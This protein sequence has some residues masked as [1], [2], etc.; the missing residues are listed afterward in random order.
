M[1]RDPQHHPRLWSTQDL[2]DYLGVAI[3]TLHA[4]RR[5]GEGPP[6]YRVGKV[7]RFDPAEVDTWLHTEAREPSP[8]PGQP[9]A[10]VPD[11]SDRRERQRHG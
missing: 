7:L 8:T 4:M 11:L 6:A 10:D 2:A 9:V 3:P 1:P 5:R